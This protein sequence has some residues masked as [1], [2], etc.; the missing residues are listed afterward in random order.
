M[1][2]L[3]NISLPIFSALWLLSSFFY[4]CDDEPT[5]DITSSQMQESSDSSNDDGD[6][7]DV[8]SSD[9]D[10]GDEDSGDGESDDDACTLSLGVSC[11]LIQEADL[12]ASNTDE[13]DYFG[14]S[15][16]PSGDTLAV[17]AYY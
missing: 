6:S 12:K 2:N 13:G 5:G 11:E 15:V 14:L 10:S 8:G 7:G 3:P 4:A 16:S 9:G 1:K 17:G